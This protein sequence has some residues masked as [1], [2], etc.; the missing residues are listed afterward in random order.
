MLAT[1]LAEKTPSSLALSAQTKPFV[2]A[3]ALT[4]A[5]LVVPALWFAFVN[6]RGRFTLFPSSPLGDVYDLQ[7]RA[8]LSGR[9]QV[10]TGALG[11][12]GFIHDGKTY[13]YFGMFPSLLRLPVM[14][15]THALDGRLTAV[16]MFISWLVICAATGACLLL[17]RRLVRGKAV[18]SSLEVATFC[19]LSATMTAG[20]IIPS[21]LA[22]PRV[23]EEDISWSIAL[24][25]SLLA[26]VLVFFLQPR[27]RWFIAISV[28][29]LCAV[30]TRGSTGNAWLLLLLGLAVFC[31]FSPHGAAWRRFGWW[32]FSLSVVGGIFIVAVSYLKFGIVYGFDERD[33]VWTQVYAPRRAFLEANGN[34]TFGL[35]FVP[36]TI[37]AY[38]DPFGLWISGLFP[39]FQTPKDAV[40]PV[41]HV[42][43]D[44]IWPT[45]SLTASAPLLFV[46]SMLGTVKATVK[47]AT[48]LDRV[49]RLVVLGTVVAIGPVLIFG[50][51]AP[52]YLGD[53]V[54][55]MVLAGATGF[56]G[57]LNR[58]EKWSEK[59]TARMMKVVI[60]LS[61]LG[62]IV[63]LAGALGIQPSWSTAQFANLT[64]AQAAISEKALAKE[65]SVKSFVPIQ[66]PPGHI[67]IVGQ[68]KGIYRTLG[69]AA[70]IT[71]R[72]I[73][74]GNWHP[75]DPTPGATGTMSI[76]ITKTP[77]RSD[78][79]L[80]L[81]TRGAM[82]LVL[83]PTGNG[84]ARLVVEHPV[85]QIP[86]VAT[87]TSSFLVTKGTTG[88]VKVTIDP[89]LHTTDIAGFDNA[90]PTALAGRGVTVYPK[91]TSTWA[92]V[93]TSRPM[94]KS[95]LCQ[96]LLRAKG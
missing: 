28:V 23:Y 51:I 31:R 76:T 49:L 1:P 73:E 93:T 37:K 36:T 21:L 80:V 24:G 67:V 95:E 22:C 42:V 69:P 6:W 64:K 75:L 27:R 91:V 65:V 13:T 12:E 26:L 46:L 3:L 18:A 53:V 9:L 88:V 40:Q 52:R 63:N 77:T 4:N 90:L 33:Q 60:F 35:Q 71:L 84:A 45:R 25:L 41:G 74:H 19:F 16:S 87:T 30:M 20:T 81:V 70:D 7:A 47:V 32:F 82:R 61:L 96:Q 44:L 43:F 78:A 57:V 14:A 39:F 89:Y 48:P 92:N 17:V 34:K 15:F 79:E 62:V 86:A 29:T 50:Y 10:P 85:A 66:A 55:W 68:C 54:P 5:I 83:R 59:W 2:R 94:A 58:T 11:V 72:L 8:L 56:Y 38:L